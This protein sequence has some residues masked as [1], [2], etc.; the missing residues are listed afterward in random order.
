MIKICNAGNNSL[1][2]AFLLHL[3]NIYVYIMSIHEYI[4]V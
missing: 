2:L 4:Y 1:D 3:K